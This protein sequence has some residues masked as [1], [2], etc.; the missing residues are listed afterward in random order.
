METP[1]NIAFAVGAWLI[2][3]SCAVCVGIIGR[4][5][6]SF[7]A[8]AASSFLSGCI[9]FGCIGAIVRSSSGIAG[10]EWYYLG[11]AVLI[12]A[13]G[14]KIYDG[15]DRRADQIIGKA[16]SKL[17]LNDERQTE[18]PDVGDDDDHSDIDSSGGSD[19][20]ADSG[21]ASGE[22]NTEEGRET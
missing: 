3:F 7:V 21:R 17:G 16:L 14:R 10:S 19:S 11:L 13:F 1:T 20:V 8:L 18:K 2:A 9:A 5:D 6:E 4:R 15:V 12:G 22:R